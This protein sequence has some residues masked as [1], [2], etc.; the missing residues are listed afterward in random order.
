MNLIN[1]AIKYTPRLGIIN[2]KVDKIY[3]LGKISH[4]KIQVIDSGIGIKESDR[5]KM[6][7]M[8]GMV[9]NSKSMIKT[10]GIGL[11][12]SIS[13]KIIKKFNG[14]INFTS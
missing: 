5:K 9:N 10:K 4:L 11:G 3:K 2:I 14:V 12:L 1:N 6:F 13:K 7:K 8:F